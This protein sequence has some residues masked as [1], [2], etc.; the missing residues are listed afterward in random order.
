MS[1]TAVA[2]G[3]TGKL[4]DSEIRK[5]AGGAAGLAIV[6]GTI[7]AFVGSNGGI[8]VAAIVALVVGVT[9]AG[10]FLL[11]VPWALGLEEPAPSVVAVLA[12]LLGLLTV[13]IFWSG[14]PPILAAAGIVLGRS[15]A[16][17]DEGRFYARAAVWLGLAV[18][19]L[20]VIRVLADV[21]SSL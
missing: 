5:I 8:V 1:Q 10:I 4:P 15:Q 14:L 6:L 18:I 21:I 16:D 19:V 7:D 20:D 13:V 17:A 11:A 3:V 2:A 12:S 9:T